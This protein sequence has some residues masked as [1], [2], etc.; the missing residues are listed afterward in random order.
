MYCAIYFV[1]FF[2]AEDGI[3]D[4]TVTG[5]QTC[6]LPISRHVEPLDDVRCLGRELRLIDGENPQPREQAPYIGDRPA[7][8]P[9]G[10]TLLAIDHLSRL[11]IVGPVE[12]SVIEQIS[13][14][15]SVECALDSLI[16]D[17]V[18]DEAEL[19]R[20]MGRSQPAR[21]V[22]GRHVLIGIV[23][24]KETC[25]RLVVPISESPGRAGR[26][27]K[28]LSLIHD[29]GPVGAGQYPSARWRRRLRRG[30]LGAGGF[31]FCAALSLDV[32]G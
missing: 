28:E 17:R 22:P 11:G 5:V 9:R 23:R 7:V 4:G 15:E 27:E 24:P 10:D 14:S 12:G 29:V 18:A 25:R 26:V 30:R 19:V 3:R 6:A 32:R 8:P 20:R 13:R 2:Q 31:L 16:V 21:N 1:F